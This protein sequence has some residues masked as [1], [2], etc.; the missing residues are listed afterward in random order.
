MDSTDK[1]TILLFIQFYSSYAEPE[2][3]DKEQGLFF[4][5]DTTSSNVYDSFCRLMAVLQ[6]LVAAF[7]P[8]STT[9]TKLYGVLFPRTLQDTDPTTVFDLDD[10]CIKVIQDRLASLIE[11]YGKCAISAKYES[12][13]FPSMCGTGTIAVI[14]LNKIAGV[15]EGTSL[16]E[17]AVLMLTDGTISDP[18]NERE[19][20]MNRLKSA[21]IETIIAARIGAGVDQNLID[22]ADK[23]DNAIA[24]NDPIEL[25]LDIVE[26]LRVE[27]ILCDEHGEIPLLDCNYSY[28]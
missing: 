8:S 2:K 19:T 9:G 12:K 14:G 25:G 20:V 6:M 13:I 24:D 11:E 17:E 28:I 27:G 22:Y 4:L 7:N 15:A 5:I 18:N 1:T 21:G 26:R 23:E 16:Q 3:C 10:V